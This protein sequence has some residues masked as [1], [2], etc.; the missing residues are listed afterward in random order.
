MLGRGTQQTGRLLRAGNQQNI[1]KIENV[2]RF[3][4]FF[5]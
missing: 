5:N 2:I 1:L 3:V 4:E